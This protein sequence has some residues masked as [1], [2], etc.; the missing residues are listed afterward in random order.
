MNVLNVSHPD[1]GSSPYLA[2]RNNYFLGQSPKRSDIP[3]RCMESA[4]AASL[5]LTE[6]VFISS[7]SGCSI[8]STLDPWTAAVFSEMSAKLGAPGDFGNEYTLLFF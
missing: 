1:P 5:L 6:T 4:A 8:A 7:P 2:K 3:S